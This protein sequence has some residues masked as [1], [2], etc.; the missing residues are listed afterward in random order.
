MYNFNG[1]E[2]KR[3]IITTMPM[4]L[5]SL[6]D[7]HPPHTC[8]F[9]PYPHQGDHCIIYSTCAQDSIKRLAPW[10]EDEK[11]VKLIA[12]RADNAIPSPSL[13]CLPTDEALAYVPGYPPLRRACFNCAKEPEAEEKLALCRQCQ[14]ARFCCLRCQQENW[15]LHKVFCKQ[16]KEQDRQQ[17]WRQGRVSCRTNMA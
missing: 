6:A 2:S 5:A 1:T 10:P 7:A 15:P 4:M 13:V 9:R 16:F 17:V 8:T 14:Y 3:T 12:C 11:Q